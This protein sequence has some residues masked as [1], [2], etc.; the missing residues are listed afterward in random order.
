MIGLIIV[1]HLASSDRA[2]LLYSDG[3]SLLNALV[4]QSIAA[5]Q[6]QH[7]MMSTVLFI[8][9]LIVYGALSLLGL[10]PSATLTLN[11]IVNVMALYAAFRYV[12]GSL[13][14]SRHPVGASLSAFA[15]FGLLTLSDHSSDRNSLELAS[16]LATTTYYS[17]TIIATVLVIGISSRLV[18]EPRQRIAS[19]LFLLVGIV[20]IST[21]SN[22][23]FTAWATIPL[24]V[25]L[26]ALTASRFLNRRRATTVFAAVLVGSLLGFICRIPLGDMTGNSAAGYLQP[27]QWHASANYY[28]KL[29]VDRVHRP[30]FIIIVIIG[31]LSLGAGIT[32][33]ILAFRRRMPGTLFIAMASWFVPLSTV[34][35][36]VILGTHAARYLQPIVFMP[37]LAIVILPRMLTGRS[38]H[39]VAS[40]RVIA[41]CGSVALAA[42]IAAGFFSVP[43]MMAGVALS[44][45]NPSLK[46]VTNWINASGRVGAGQYWTV[47]APKLHLKN[48]R[49]LVQVDYHLNPYTW[50]V[51]R[52]DYENVSVTF[53]ITAAEQFPFDLPK[54]LRNVRTTKIKCGT[55]TITDFGGTQLPLGPPHS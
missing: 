45:S 48:P 44:N 5:G 29:A 13:N 9:E 43:R 21:L 11:A 31:V 24:S 46:C 1:G 39:K 52:A 25:V 42:F 12:A 4:V 7:W 55:Y 33:T 40:L 8:P 41:V 16:L 19:R 26:A 28:F 50:L 20:A 23:I 3:D 34:A 22:P 18:E 49:Q 51:N 30:E 53:L 37:L 35:G 54:D 14:I 27:N 6:A 15:L 32:C 10:S 2:V 47:R 38:T 17:T 36:A